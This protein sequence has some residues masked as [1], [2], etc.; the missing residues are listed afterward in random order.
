MAVHG[1][2]SLAAVP[3][4]LHPGAQSLASYT[5][6]VWQP[7]KKQW[8]VIWPLAIF[9]LL[10]W[11][12][13]DGSLA[14]KGIRWL[15]DPNGTLPRLPPSLSME[16]GDNADAVAEHDAE[17]QAYYAV[18]ARSG[19]A[20]TRLRLTELNDPFDPATERQL[21]I[22]ILVIGALVVWRIGST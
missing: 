15:A 5:R 16:L 9:V 1:P 18:S 13:A 22:G 8:R 14:V 2:C 4:S 10:A 17:E 7:G 3:W 11:P 6:P 12:A 21:L 19:W 20:R